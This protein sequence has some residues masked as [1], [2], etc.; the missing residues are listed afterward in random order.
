MKSFT[1]ILTAISIFLSS[2]GNTSSEISTKQTDTINEEGHTH[3][4]VTNAIELNNG[5]KWKVVPEMLLHIRNMENDVTT[6][7]N[8]A[9]N[10]YKSLSLKL[11]SSIDLLTSNCTMEGKAHDELHKWLLPYI[12]LVNDLAESKD[13]NESAKYFKNIQISFTTFNQYFQ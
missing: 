1:I 13:K 10:D 11:Q 4:K 8:T 9:Q 2:C 3:D 12:D 5:E 6:Y 7:K